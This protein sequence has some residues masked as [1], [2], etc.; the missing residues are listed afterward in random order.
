MFVRGEKFSL[1]SSEKKMEPYVMK[2]SYFIY[3][4]IVLLNQKLDAGPVLAKRH[5]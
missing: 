1:I 2:I 3:D 4:Y 5:H